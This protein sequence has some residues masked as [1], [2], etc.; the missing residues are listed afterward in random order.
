MRSWRTPCAIRTCH[1]TAFRLPS[2]PFSGAMHRDPEV[3]YP[4]CAEFVAELRRA[5]REIQDDLTPHHDEGHRG[6]L[7]VPRDQVVV[8]P[9]RNSRGLSG[10]RTTTTKGREP[11]PL[12]TCRSRAPIDQVCRR[13]RIERHGRVTGEEIVVAEVS[14]DCRRSV[15]VNSGCWGHTELEFGRHIK[16]T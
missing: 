12:R 2:K 13:K 4:T 11:T 8:T 5:S 6:T 16:S 15:G 7:H 10:N 9:P 3:R 1:L 14:R